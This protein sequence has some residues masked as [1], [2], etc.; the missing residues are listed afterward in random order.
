MGNICNNRRLMESADLPKVMAQFDIELPNAEVGKVVTRFPPEA[1]GYLHVGHVK[2]AMLNEYYAENYKGKLLLRFDDTNPVKERGEFEAAIVEDLKTVGIVPYRVTYTSDYFELILHCGDEMIKM[3]KAYIDDLPVEVMRENRKA[4][5]ESARRTA[6]VEEN[7]RLWEEMK[8]GS[9]E[10]KKCV[11]RAK[12]DMKSVN[13]ALRDP[14][15]FRVIDLPHARTGERY[16]A[17]PCYDF[18]CPIVDS[19]EGVTVSMRTIEYRD[20]NEQFHW[21][22]KALGLREVPIYDFARLNFQ[23]TAMSKRQLQ[24]FV[25]EGIVEGWFDPRFPTVQGMMR[26]GLTVPAL[27]AFILEQGPSRNITYQ[28]WD[29]IWSK[30]KQVI[31]PIAPRYTAIEKENAVRVKLRDGPARA[32]DAVVP[33]HRKNRAV[34]DKLVEFSS[35]ILI[36]QCDAELLK[37][38]EEVTLMGWGNIVIE[39]IERDERL[40]IELCVEGA[41]GEGGATMVPAVTEVTARMHLEGD[42]KKTKLKLTWLSCGSA[43]SE[44]E[45][46]L[47]TCK[48]VAFDHLLTKA[49]MGEEDDFRD[50]ANRNSRIETEVYVEPAAVFGV[51]GDII[52]FER[53]G[54]FYLDKPFEEGTETKAASGAVFHFIPDGR[55][56]FMRIRGIL[57]KGISSAPAKTK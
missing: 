52:Q 44:G 54:F 18:A 13:T 27:R 43:A 55:N 19:V 47:P 48:I 28:E 7:Q 24:W 33:R 53:K 14:V 30:N 12:I 32:Y 31:D 21:I 29:K 40:M 37:E 10:G 35:D 36:E 41:G 49:K 34:G 5:I 23:Y 6:S 57:P 42:F 50:Y 22:Q 46:N 9:E 2:A 20:R 39:K 3:G 25:D 51:S 56:N 26:R 45:Y 16:K 4:G 8:K 38:G 15:L 1:S 17:Y 11:M